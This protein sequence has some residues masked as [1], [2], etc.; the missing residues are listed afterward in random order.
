MKPCAL[1]LRCDPER[2]DA[3]GAIIF[4][5]GAEDVA[6]WMCK[7]VYVFFSPKYHVKQ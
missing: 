7:H 1:M 3:M 4:S 2:K 5:G 6:A